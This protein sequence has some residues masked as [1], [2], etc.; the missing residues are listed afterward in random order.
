MATLVTADEKQAGAISQDGG[1][2]AREGLAEEDVE[3]LRDLADRYAEK[4]DL[5]FVAFLGRT[6][7]FAQILEAGVRRLDHSPEHERRVAL[8]EVAE[9]AGDR[10]GIM[11][12]DANPIGSAWARKFESLQ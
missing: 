2:F 9:I 10:F 12:A 7:S 4:F 3:A 6:D 8:T 11:V 1:A 5:P